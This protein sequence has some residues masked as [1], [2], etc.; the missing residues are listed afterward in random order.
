MT[1]RPATDRRK[2]PTGRE[3]VAAA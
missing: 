1:T 3:E 2:M